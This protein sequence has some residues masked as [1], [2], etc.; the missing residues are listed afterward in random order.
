MELF[1]FKDVLVIFGLSIV[2]LLGGSYLKV[3]PVVGFLVTGVLAGP[4]G[5]GLVA[6]LEDVDMLAQVGILLLLFGIGMEFSLSKLAE[7]KRL[8]FL[9]GALQ[10]A[11]TVGVCF[12]AVLCAGRSWQSALFFGFLISLSSTAVVLRLLEEKG[13]SASPQGRLSLAMLIFQDLIAIPM[14]LMTPFL[15]Q[16]GPIGG[17]TQ[18][19]EDLFKGVAVL[20]I[21]F[22]SAEKWVPKLLF[23]VTRT[24]NKELFLV[25]VLTLCFGVAWLTAAL[26]LSL[27]IGAFLAGLI[28]SESEYSN[29]AVSR[30]FPFQALFISFFFVSIGMLLDVQF[31]L[32]H[33]ISVLSMALVIFA[34][35]AAV[36]GFVAII[37]QFPI[38]TAVLVGV[39][40]SQIGEFSFVLAKAGMP[41][42]LLMAEEYQLF[43]AVSLVTLTVSPF[44]IEISPQF[45]AWFARLPMPEKMRTGLALPQQ[46][47]VNVQDHLIIIGFGISGRNLARAAKTMHIPYVVLE[48]N[49]ETVRREKAGGETIFFGDASQETVLEH[50][51]IAQARSVAVLINDAAA[52]RQIIKNV[53][54]MNPTAYI[55]IRIRYVQEMA[56]MYELG[57]DAVI[58]DEFGTSIEVFSRV[59]RQYQVP[60][61]EIQRLITEVRRE[62]YELLRRSPNE[63][64]NLAEIKL[65]LAGLEV[66]SFRL[67]PLSPLVGRKLADSQLRQEHAM[68]V[69][70]IR[71]GAQLLANPSSDTE[72]Q[73]EDVLI[74]LGERMTQKSGEVFAPASL[75]VPAT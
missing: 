38:R 67:H 32:N 22:L 68:T 6:H 31:V 19:V 29:E 23:F 34:V 54:A 33:P 7:M 66:G 50:L 25:S 49:P 40:V 10:V 36:A 58:P 57:A 71:R 62:G 35:K 24:R 60:D 4:H 53:R 16:E 26:G 42:G 44:L 48:M 72:L 52:A 27:T 14:I 45:A 47:R 12:F 20:A 3:P 69:L 59:L 11:C 30:I 61:S 9:G 5:L 46:S 73:A 18:L 63:L 64:G 37:L 41:Y 21:V 65:D 56:L 15:S 8:F 17:Q 43:L 28:I 74:V 39:A 51:Q 1:F 70:L 55:I 13:E 75:M 2:V